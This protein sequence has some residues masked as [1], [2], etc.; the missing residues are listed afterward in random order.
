MPQVKCLVGPVLP[1]DLDWTA[2]C[3]KETLF[4]SLTIQKYNYLQLGPLQIALFAYPA[5]TP[6]VTYMD[7]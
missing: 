1:P 6:L 2:L 5:A 7:I 4:I 3:L